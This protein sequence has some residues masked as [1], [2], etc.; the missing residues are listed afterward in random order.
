MCRGL[1]KSP[2]A[3]DSLW[4]QIPIERKKKNTD[5]NKLVSEVLIVPKF[6]YYFEAIKHNQPHIGTL[7]KQRYPQHP[8][9]F[10]LKQKNYPLMFFSDN[11][12]IIDAIFEDGRLN[13]LF[14][15]IDESTSFLFNMFTIHMTDQ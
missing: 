6:G 9:A 15:N 3:T 12:E 8:C 10:K 13:T 2:V 14:T 5:E 1:F 4:L 11:Q 7:L